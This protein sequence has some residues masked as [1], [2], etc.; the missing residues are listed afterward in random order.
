M[1][2]D[3][4]LKPRPKRSRI[5]ALALTLSF[6][7]HLALLPILAF[8]TPPPPKEIAP[9]PPPP[10]L[11]TLTEPPPP[12]LPPAP[13]PAP[14]APTP[15]PAPAAAP[16]AKT[17]TPAPQK[18]APAPKAP[19]PPR[20]TQRPHPAPPTP[21]APAPHRTPRPA[22]PTVE[23]RQVAETP[24]PDTS[25]LLTEA[26]LVGATTAGSSPTGGPGAGVTPG[27]GAGAGAG[28]GSG[29]GSGSGSGSGG[30]CDMVQRLQDAL[31]DDARIRAAVT[32]AHEASGT[33]QAMLVWNGDWIRS[34]GQDG[35]GLAGVRQAIAL[36]VAFAPPA[37]R[38]QA[39]RGLVLLRFSD[40]PGGPRL[41]LGTGRWRWSDLTHASGAA[42]AS[43]P[44][45][46]KPGG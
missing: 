33:G 40:A 22:P 24:G 35:K 12:P 32:R 36:E 27:G 11:V 39:M 43:I 14:A 38:S 6:A 28:A 5:Y 7:V 1:I 3:R 31:R 9:P 20:P 13:E 26:Q 21:R 2:N 41:A 44:A 46:I 10:I 25:N 17:P 45:S 29:N 19:Q 23:A 30:R 16:A 15:D 34:Q 8:T 37:C 42:P 4:Y 18:A